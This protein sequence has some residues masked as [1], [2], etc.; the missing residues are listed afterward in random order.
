M[1]LVKGNLSGVAWSATVSIVSLPMSSSSNGYLQGIS[2]GGPTTT[3]G[4]NGYE[5][6]N[7][8]PAITRS[9]VEGNPSTPCL[10]ILYPSM[11]RFRWVVKPG[12]RRI[13]VRVKQTKHHTGSYA[14]ETHPT[15]IIKSNPN[16]GLNVDLSATS[17]ATP[18]W[19]LLGP[20]VFTA[21]GM[22]AVWVELHNNAVLDDSPAYFDHIAIS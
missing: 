9:Y 15:M 3:W 21:T 4:G 16:V 13:S 18:D 12:Q 8:N 2:V 6:L 14:Y 17:S 7:L 10:T 5:I 19:T 22:D 20:I 1:P 11:W